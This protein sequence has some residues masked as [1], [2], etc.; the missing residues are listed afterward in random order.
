MELGFP[1]NPFTLDDAELGVLDVNHLDGTLLGDDVAEYVTDLN[2]NRGRSDQL[3]SFSAGTATISVINNDRRFDPINTASPYYDP[4]SGRSGIQPRRK[5][6][7]ILQGETVFTGRLTDFDVQYALGPNQTST[8]TFSASDEFVTLAT[9]VTEQDHIPAGELSGTRVNY[10][11]DLPEVNF[12]AATRNIDAGTAPLGAYTI[13][14]N[15]NVL[16]YLQR[17]EK[18]EQ[19]FLFVD[20]SGSLTF[21]DRVSA[22]FVTPSA[23]FND[24]GTDLPYSNLSTVAG[25]EFFFN[26]IVTKRD[27]GTEQVA[28]S[29]SSQTE[30]GI[31]T[32]ALTD[33][34]L[35][36]DADALTLADS[37]LERFSEPSYRFDVLTVDLNALGSVDR[38]TLN[39]L[40]LADVINV[41]RNFATGSPASVSLD[42]SIDRIRHR[43][44]PS[45]HV[46]EIGLAAVDI[47]FP[48]VLDD[49]TF[50][51]LDTSN[52]LT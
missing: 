26:K 29:A 4:T 41:T 22:S 9:Q 48:F 8:V 46:L 39:E 13:A 18:A 43:V 5:V 20:R 3:S 34:L 25:Q 1:V 42:F 30:F 12:P 32:L 45:A 6:T 37:L 36:D 33:L 21:T 24:D 47:I 16:T 10:V 51:T 19:G 15:T 14:A 11:L 31:L 27:G 28:N 44:T 23:L 38:A 2:I 7:V 17:I 35:D 50:G 52:A 40:E 49:P